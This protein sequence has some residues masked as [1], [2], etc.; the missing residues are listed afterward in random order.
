MNVRTDPPAD[1][2]TARAP[3]ALAGI[4]A[5]LHGF[6]EGETALARR[7]DMRELHD[8]LARQIAA[9]REQPEPEPPPALA[10]LADLPARIGALEAAVLRVEAAVHVDLDRHVARAIGEALDRREAEGRRRAARATLARA[11]LALACAGLLAMLLV[12]Y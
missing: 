9:L 11:A 4:S 8:R 12:V 5:V 3:S 10:A 6:A 1:D 2:R 7:R